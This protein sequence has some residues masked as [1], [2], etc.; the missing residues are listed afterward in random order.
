MVGVR[1]LSETKSFKNLTD[2]WVL[3]LFQRFRTSIR[4]FF[5]KKKTPKNE[6]PDAS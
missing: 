2:Q 1:E 3:P 5:E 4:R 6:A